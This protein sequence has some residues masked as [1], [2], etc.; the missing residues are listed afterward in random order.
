M[1]EQL[2][3]TWTNINIKQE[4]LLSQ[5]DRATVAWSLFTVLHRMQTRSSD[6]N[7]VRRSVCLSHA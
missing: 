2:C 1:P 5:R 4:A 7:S 3:T 6:E